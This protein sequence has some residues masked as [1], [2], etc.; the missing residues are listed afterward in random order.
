MPDGTV[1]NLPT[2]LQPEALLQRANHVPL[3]EG[4]LEQWASELARDTLRIVCL[5]E[6]EA[7]LASITVQITDIRG[8]LAFLESVGMQ[9]VECTRSHKQSACA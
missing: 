3:A 5:D 6:E 2:K 9:L 4:A 8:R 7:M 1:L